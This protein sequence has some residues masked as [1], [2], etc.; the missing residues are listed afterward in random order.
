MSR[1][2]GSIHGY[3]VHERAWNRKGPIDNLG[4]RGGVRL[5]QYVWNMMG[6]LNESWPELFYC[7][8]TTEVSRLVHEEFQHEQD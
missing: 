6:K 4:R 3:Y 2:N 8:T 1:L 7:K 5:G